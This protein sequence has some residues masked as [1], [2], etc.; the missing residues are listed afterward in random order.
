MKLDPSIIEEFDAYLRKDL[1][2]AEA[3]KLEQR[4]AAYPD[5]KA[6]FEQHKMTLEQLAN[7]PRLREYKA[8][9]NTIRQKMLAEQSAPELPKKESFFTWKNLSLLLLVALLAGIAG[10][11]LGNQKVLPEPEGKTETPV[12]KQPTP[13]VAQTGEEDEPLIGAGKKWGSVRFKTPVLSIA[14]AADSIEIVLVEGTRQQAILEQ[15][16][17]ALHYLPGQMPEVKNIRL[18]M[19]TKAGQKVL[20]MKMESRW[21]SIREGEQE[22]VQEKEDAL[23]WMESLDF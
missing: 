12:Q 23:K 18:Y 17:L 2:A 5:L 19:L 6:A 3:E 4:L 20:Y 21:F 22:L 11:W 8:A 10:Y 16:T 9:V 1:S 7:L 13:P 14:P 15:N